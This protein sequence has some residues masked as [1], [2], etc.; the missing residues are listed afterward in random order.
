ME[1]KT[2]KQIDNQ[3]KELPFKVTMANKFLR[4]VT[5]ARVN[6]NLIDWDGYLKR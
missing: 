1:T 5:I 3:L 4:L 6:H 2:L